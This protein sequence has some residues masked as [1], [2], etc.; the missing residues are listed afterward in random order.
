MWSNFKLLYCL[1]GKSAHNFPYAVTCMQLVFLDC[2]LL[3]SRVHSDHVCVVFLSLLAPNTVPCT[4][5][6]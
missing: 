3:E 5:K 1:L 4:Q 2:A 6:Q